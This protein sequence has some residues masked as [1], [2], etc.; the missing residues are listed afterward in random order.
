M[1]KQVWNGL[2]PNTIKSGYH[3]LHR[4]SWRSLSVVFWDHKLSVWMIDSATIL[5]DYQAAS[6]FDYVEPVGWA[7]VHEVSNNHTVIL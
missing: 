1:N 4:K 3:W 6:M 7:I 2:P 5:E